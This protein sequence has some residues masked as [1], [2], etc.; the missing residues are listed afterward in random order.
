MHE[1]L[2]K[3]TRPDLFV[4][5]QALTILYNVDPK[6]LFTK[7]FDIGQNSHGLQFSATYKIYNGRI[8]ITLT[9]EEIIG[10]GSKKEF[11]RV[12]TNLRTNFLRNIPPF[13]RAKEAA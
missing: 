11:L 2:I 7:S 13:W 1:S 4:S 8:R 9:P 12:H 10:A 5:N 6:D 3:K